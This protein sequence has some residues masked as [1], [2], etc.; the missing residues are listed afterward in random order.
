VSVPELGDIMV[1]AKLSLRSNFAIQH[2]RVAIRDAHSAHAVE[3]ANDTTKFGSWFDDMMLHVPVAVVMAAAA[4]EANSSE[5]IQDILD[6]STRVH[7][8]D[9]RK[10][11][12]EDLRDDRSG[13]AM[14]KYRKLSLFLDKMPAVG[15]TAW[16]NADL[17]F[18]FRNS[19]MH[20]KPAWDNEA[21]VHD[22]KLVRGLKTQVPISPAYQTNFMFPYGFLTYGCA[23]WAVESAIAFSAEFCALADVT[24]RFAGKSDLP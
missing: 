15:G 16:Q 23:K 13:N 22:S 6:K 20:F 3:K 5:I 19:F 2:L 17:L 4:L 8:T 1:G 14:G 24:D 21:D 9:T 7:L 10:A 11:L 18:R 12:L